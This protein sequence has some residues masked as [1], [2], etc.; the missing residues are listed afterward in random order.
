MKLA[1]ESISAVAAAAAIVVP[2][3]ATGAAAQADTPSQPNTFG[4]TGAEQTYTVPAG[5][6]YIAASLIGGT[7]GESC[8]GGSGGSGATLAATIPVTP[9]EQLYVNVGQNGHGCQV[10]QPTFGGGGGGV[11]GYMGSSGGGASDIRTASGDLSSRL[12]VAAGGGG[13]ADGAS[14]YFSGGGAGG[15]PGGNGHDGYDDSVSSGGG[16]GGGT[17]SAGGAGGSSIYTPGGNGSLGQ[18]GSAGAI[19]YS[20]GGGGGGYYGGGGGG[21][22]GGGGGGSSYAEPAALHVSGGTD[23]TATPQITIGPILTASATQLTFPDT[24]TQSVGAAQ[25]ITITNSGT[26]PVTIGLK[27]DYSKG[28]NGDDYLVS[29]NTCTGQLAAGASC[30]VR[31]KFNPQ[32]TGASQSALLL[33]AVDSAGNRLEAATVALSGNGTGLPP[34]PAG[35]QGPQDGQ[36]PTGP[37][38]PQGGEGPT[39]TQGPAGKSTTTLLPALTHLTL[40]AHRMT[41]TPHHHAHVKLSF[42]LNRTATVTLKLQRLEPGHWQTI[43]TERL[44]VNKG[45][46][47]V[48][49]GDTFARHA[50]TAGSYLLTAQANATGMHSAPVSSTLTVHAAHTR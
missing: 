40:S 41:L 42:T 48:L 5:V 36:G 2:L 29:A 28:Q 15:L 38:G 23:L 47:T 10:D 17:L 43:G 25:A 21:G 19:H 22:E 13:G 39:G 33:T 37:Q 4:Y 9:G 6:H 31:V 34:G 44:T 11:S 32:G 24:P 18:G 1:R 46:H 16:G 20:G 50:L 27:F 49:L 7:G 14:P 3:A 30:T 35:P 12:L 26:G 45:Q 8:T